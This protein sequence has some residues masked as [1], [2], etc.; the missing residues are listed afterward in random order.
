MSSCRPFR[1][2]AGIVVAMLFLAALAGL[3]H[4][5]GEQT[6][7]PSAEQVADLLR[8]E[9]ITMQT[10]PAWSKR[11]RGWITDRSGNTNAAYEAAH[12]FCRQ[13]AEATG[14]LPAPLATDALAWYMLGSAYLSDAGKNNYQ[15]QGALA[16]KALRESIRLD[17]QFARAHRN[18]ARA[19]LLQV[20]P[21]GG[22]PPNPELAR[23]QERVKKLVPG[24]GGARVVPLL[25]RSAEARRELDEARRL[26]PTLALAWVEA[27]AALR[28]E[29]FA[30]AER[31]FAE[32]ARQSPDDAQASARGQ[33]LAIVKNPGRAGPRAAAVKALLDRD[34]NDGILV[35]LHGVA[36]A[37]DDDA[38]AAVREFARARQLGTEPATILSPDTVKKIEELGAPSWLEWGT[39]IGVGFVAFYA[40][41]MLL[42]AV[43]G[44]ILASRTRGT[45]A[46]QMVEGEVERMV[47]DGQ[48]ART[49]HESWL[50]TAYALA[51]M[52]G[53]LLFYLAIP[54]LVVGLLGG[55]AALLYLVFLLPRIP[56]KLIVI[57]VVVGGGAAWAVLKSV[58]ARPG[59][60][61]F[62]I[63]KTAEE[64]PRLYE[65]L[66]EVAHRVDT[67]PVDEVYLAPG[68]SIG[69]H[70]EG[71]GPFGLFGVKR[72][73]LTLGLS[74][75]HF[76]TV[77]ELKSILA[78]EYAHF[79]HKDTF[80]SRFIYQVTLS[81]R[82]AL[83]GMGSSGGYF[84]YVNPVY[85]FL[86]LYH[87]CYDLLSAGFS[88]SREFLADRMA[89]TLYGSDTFTSALTKVST[90]GTL[91]EMTM[92]DSIN[93]LLGEGKAYVNMYTAF[94]EFRDEQMKTEDRDQ[95]YQKLL[96]EK[97]SLFASH[98]TFRERID[99]VAPLP[100]ADRRDDTPAVGLFDNVEELEKE[101]TD[102]LTGVAQYIQQLQAQAA[103]AQE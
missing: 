50:A 91:F 86:F 47:E 54:F 81:I 20:P 65:A 61:A 5:R 41:V 24:A 75:M 103:A 95:L 11:L 78:H 99:A 14:G 66:A 23:L 79:S 38:R 73:V 30:D 52:L 29:R 76:L 102:F 67:S 2:C 55:T 45:R 97:G 7:I 1:P 3:P 72:R 34:P 28:Q 27:E 53:L 63:P 39:W 16:E 17:P 22:P 25:D 85:W 80:Y 82:E 89:A 35:T 87:K 43:A 100:S 94:R 48:V 74:T 32:A 70:Q 6:A 69:V 58:F 4:A 18:L 90:D 33:A 77:G 56:V 26:E 57:V 10:W 19:L 9:P 36:L 13:Q 101:L 93:S 31:L 84:N 46:L 71:R 21:G 64:C 15:K 88:R 96:D 62:G 40:A 59:T 60:G 51:L 12:A 37:Q 49:Q 83:N 42:M 8:R 68:A 98:P 92:Y 44:V